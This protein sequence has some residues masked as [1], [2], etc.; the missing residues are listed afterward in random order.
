MNNAYSSIE[1]QYGLCIFYALHLTQIS[2]VCT[3]HHIVQHLIRDESAM[4]YGEDE[5][6][7]GVM[8]T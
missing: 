8:N 5:T 3:L 7:V 2:E 4:D 6:D 1:Y